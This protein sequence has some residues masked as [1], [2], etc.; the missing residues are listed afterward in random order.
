MKK[1][2]LASASPRRQEILTL[3]GFKFEVRVS[4]AEDRIQ[5]E[6]IEKLAPHEQVEKLAQCKAK[7]IYSKYAKNEDIL[8][9]GADTVVSV[10][11]RVLGKPESKEDAIQMLKRLSGRTHE[12]Y[13]GVC[14][15]EKEKQKTF[16]CLTEVSFYEMSDEEIEAY[17]ASG[18]C[19]DK[20]GAYAI[21]G[22]AAKFICGIK[23]DYFNVVGL[24]L[25]RLYH[26]I[27]QDA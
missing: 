15:I 23:G 8:V 4:D 17:V 13:T 1:I 22:G 20:A 24:P 7:D 16:S 2:I 11:G 6:E 27:V 9:V 18:E 5:K 25:S 19:Y 21:Q 12:V 14:L 10:D 3:G 26:E